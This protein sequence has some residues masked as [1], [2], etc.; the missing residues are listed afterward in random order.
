MGTTET[1]QE[2]KRHINTGEIFALPRSRL[3]Q[4]VAALAHPL[5]YTLF[6]GPEFP[7][8]CETAK[9]AL[10]L[11]VSEDANLQAKKESRLALIIACTALMVGTVQAVAALWPFV[12]PSPTLVRASTPVPIHAPVPIPVYVVPAAP[13]SSPQV[14]RPASQ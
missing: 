8:I 11:R 14:S 5:A 1:L 2:L 12:S 6:G 7:R 10:S 9:L 4:F 13:A 3:E